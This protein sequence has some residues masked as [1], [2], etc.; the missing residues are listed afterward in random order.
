MELE[1]LKRGD[2]TKIANYMRLM[3]DA[4]V[5]H[6]RDGALEKYVKQVKREAGG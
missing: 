3:L 5:L 1:L 6:N 2:V 4:E